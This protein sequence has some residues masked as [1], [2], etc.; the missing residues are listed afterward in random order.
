M[1]ST[2][3][4]RFQNC[5]AK[6][7]LG[8][9][10]Q[11]LPCVLTHTG[12]NAPIGGEVS[13]IRLAVGG[14]VEV[15]ASGQRVHVEPEPAADVG[16]EAIVSPEI[17]ICVAEESVVVL[18][19]ARRPVAGV[20]RVVE[21]A[22]RDAGGAAHSGQAIR[23]DHRRLT[24]SSGAGSVVPRGVE[25]QPVVPPITEPGAAGEVRGRPVR[26]AADRERRAEGAERRQRDGSRTKRSARGRS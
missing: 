6:A 4:E 13:G 7:M 24:R 20:G 15:D 10:R 8:C 11:R 9:G 2:R 26:S 17:D 23:A 1:S 25:P 3:I 18:V 14:L 5:C 12:G 19:Q 21:K 22:K 16:R